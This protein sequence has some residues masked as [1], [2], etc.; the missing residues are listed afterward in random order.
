MTAQISIERALTETRKLLPSLN[1]FAIAA[2][3]DCLLLRN[4]RLEWKPLNSWETMDDVQ[5]LH[6]LI[7]EI[8]QDGTLLMIPDLCFWGRAD[9]FLVVTGEV[10]EFVRTFSSRFGVAFFNG[11]TICVWPERRC[12]YLFDHHG[13]YAVARV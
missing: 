5:I 13:N 11:D 7:P 8:S 10:E 9:P 6:V 1:S 4:H 3:H 2:I 12:F